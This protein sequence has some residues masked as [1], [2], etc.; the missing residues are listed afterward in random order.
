M[1][2]II[3]GIMVSVMLVMSVSLA[4][5]MGPENA[6]GKDVDELW[7]DRAKLYIGPD[8]WGAGSTPTTTEDGTSIGVIP[9]TT[10]MLKMVWFDD[11]DFTDKDFNLFKFWLSGPVEITFIDG[12]EY[13]A[14]KFIFIKMNYV[15]IGS[16]W[17]P[18]YTLQAY[19]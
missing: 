17:T 14:E 8:Y 3:L 7:N 16:V 18:V 13:T 19:R 4:M 1:K 15:L 12:T 11:D 10:L 5:A 2:K 9:S 6:G